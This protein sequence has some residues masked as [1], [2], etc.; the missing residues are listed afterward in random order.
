VLDNYVFGRVPEAHSL[1]QI[2]NYELARRQGFGGWFKY[3]KD[4]APGARSRFFSHTNGPGRTKRSTG[5]GRKGALSW[6]RN[7]QSH[8]SWSGADAGKHSRGAKSRWTDQRY[9]LAP[10]KQSEG[11]RMALTMKLN[12]E[13]LIII[14]DL[15]FP[16]PSI[17][18]MRDWSHSWGFDR[19]RM[20]AYII[21]GGTQWA[22]RMEMD[23]NNFWT[24]VFVY[25]LQIQETRSVNAY[26]ALRYRYLVM[27]EGAVTQLERFFDA[28]KVA[29]L[30]PHVAAKMTHKLADLDEKE[31]DWTTVD[32]EGAWEVAKEEEKMLDGFRDLDDPWLNGQRWDDN[33]QRIRE[34][35]K[36]VASNLPRLGDPI[37]DDMREYWEGQQTRL[38]PVDELPAEKEY[39]HP[40]QVNKNRTG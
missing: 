28:E 20:M 10:L 39:Q 35:R 3:R 33:E 34:H 24:N 36:Y 8:N 2:M 26:D 14:D 9:D 6:Q 1:Y 22:P 17:E 12:K 18:I 7:L 37:N 30:P 23:K 15:K 40:W 16:V 4:E 31:W 38:P 21:D 27:T 13:Q 11:L 5:G 29:S 32:E 25:G 19:D